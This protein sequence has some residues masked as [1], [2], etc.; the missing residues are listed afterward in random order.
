[1]VHLGRAD[2]LGCVG[3]NND[4]VLVHDYTTDCV[5]NIV[6]LVEGLG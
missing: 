5:Q 4:A 6:E 2:L 3:R 1:M